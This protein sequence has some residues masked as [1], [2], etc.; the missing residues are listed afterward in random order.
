[1]SNMTNISKIWRGKQIALWWR[2]G[3]NS[4]SIHLIS[5]SPLTSARIAVRIAFHSLCLFTELFDFLK[6]QLFLFCSQYTKRHV[7][8]LIFHLFCIILLWGCLY[9]N[10]LTNFGVF[11]YK[12]MRNMHLWGFSGKLFTRWIKFRQ[13]LDYHKGRDIMI[14]SYCGIKIRRSHLNEHVMTHHKPPRFECQGCGRN[15]HLKR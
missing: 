15:F 1:M 2:S 5:D 11:K 7:V 6:F 14:C 9:V 10:E 13:H 12:S 8:F 3:R 4:A